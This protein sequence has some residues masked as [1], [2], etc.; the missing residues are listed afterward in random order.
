MRV[1]DWYNSEEG[2][3]FMNYGDEVFIMN[4]RMA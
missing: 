1:L 4:L 3:M 2:M